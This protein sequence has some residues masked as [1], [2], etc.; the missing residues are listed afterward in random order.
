MATVE[1][2]A[3]TAVPARTEAGVREV[4]VRR[5][6]KQGGSPG[7]PKIRPA[8][9]WD[10]E[11]RYR[12]IAEAAYLR[13]EQRGF[14]PGSELADWLAAELEVDDILEVADLPDRA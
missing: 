4:P 3:R 13:A 12:M 14:V 10:G 9:A 5:E 2:V 6:A 8:A 11:D 7:S 1:V